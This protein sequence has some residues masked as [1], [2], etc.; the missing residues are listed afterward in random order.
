MEG[1]KKDLG[2]KIDEDSFDAII[3][4]EVCKLEAKAHQIE[5]NSS[6]KLEELEKKGEQGL[7]AIKREIEDFRA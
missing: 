6:L 7:R 1:I 3:D 4:W 5:E 2:T